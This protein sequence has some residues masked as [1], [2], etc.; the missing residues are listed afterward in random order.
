MTTRTYPQGVRKAAQ[1]LRD[2]AQ[3][4]GPLAE[5]VYRLHLLD[6]AEK[7]DAMAVRAD[8]TIDDLFRDRPTSAFQSMQPEASFQ[9]K[10]S[11]K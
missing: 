6:A 7:L 5:N 10:I 1:V 2:E 3:G 4:M 8:R 11:I 9:E